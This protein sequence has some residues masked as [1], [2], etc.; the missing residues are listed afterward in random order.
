MVTALAVLGRSR[1]S[2]RGFGR[3]AASVYERNVWVY[4]TNWLLIASGML[5]PLLYLGSVG[6]GFGRLVGTVPT[7]S[8]PIPYA[9]FVAPA[10]LATS[11]MNGAIY[12]ASFN[13]FFKLKFMKLYDGVLATPVRPVDIAAGEVG[14]SLTRGLIYAVTFL[15]VMA[16][17]GLFRSPWGLL[18]LPASVLVGLCFGGLGVLA[19]CYMRGW[20]D[21]DI[22]LLATLP[23][24]LFS[25]T[26]FPLAGYP[27][28]VRLI[29]QATP[30]YNGNA[31]MRSLTLGQVS[32][33]TLAHAVY[34]AVLGIGGIALAGRRLQHR[35][36]R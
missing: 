18:A 14:W 34:L 3:R 7:V 28:V 19:T 5:E 23:M 10:L 6:L 29:V 1:A 15:V 27:P 25:A 32:W 12:D 35:L 22:V 26:F 11:A 16:A 30:L 2:S 9:Q 31:L 33:V 36:L 24:F 21:L 13:V 17:A 4:R 20:Q 8:G